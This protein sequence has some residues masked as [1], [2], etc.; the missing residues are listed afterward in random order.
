MA[1]GL[2]MQ[3]QSRGQMWG[4]QRGGVGTTQ[5]LEGQ[6]D[7]EKSSDRCVHGG[8]SCVPGTVLSTRL[9]SSHLS[10]TTGVVPVKTLSSLR[11]WGA[12]SEG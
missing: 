5:S 1:I 9:G 8:L 12:G 7:V 2:D 6:N 10:L 3:G 11:S 4:H